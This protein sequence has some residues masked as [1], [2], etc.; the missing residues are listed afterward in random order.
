[1]KNMIYSI[2]LGMSVFSSAVLHAAETPTN[3]PASLLSATEKKAS[4]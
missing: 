3:Q 4:Y 1:M 2:L